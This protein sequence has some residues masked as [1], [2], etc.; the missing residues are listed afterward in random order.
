VNPAAYEAYL[1][2]NFYW[3][4]LS[5]EGFSKGRE[6][7]QRAVD[8]DP[9]FA[10]AYVG[11]SES[12]FT[13]DN[14]RCSYQPELIPKSRAAAL[15]ALELDPNSGEAHAW[16]GKLA[17]FYE[18]DFPKAEAELKRGIELEPNYAASRLVY[19]VLLVTEGRR[20]QGLAELKIA[21]ELDPISQV[22]G[23]VSVFAL[24]LDRQYD[25]AIEQGNKT[26]EL[27]PGSTGTY[28]WLGAAYEKRGLYDRANAA[29]LKSKELTGASPTE[30]KT[31]RSAYRESGIRGY[32][33]LELKAAEKTGWS[34]CSMTEIYAHL[35][36]RERA[37]EFLKRSLQQHCSG[38]HTVIADPVYDSFRDDP[39][40]KSIMTQLRLPQM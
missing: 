31:Y 15:K 22:T 3:N 5:C 17:F 16:L 20:E 11:L 7:F 8:E 28:D 13:L 19:A 23:V 29:Y 14:W 30:L 39:S 32:W 36:D 25:R 35:G 21:N 34:A 26:I 4:Q 37:L 38:P 12:N 1:R 27:Y 9:G 18:W 24:Y 10:A 6:F 2:G 40:F 33:Q